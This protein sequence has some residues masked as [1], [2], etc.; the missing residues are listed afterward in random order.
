M[1]YYSDYQKIIAISKSKSGVNQA[2]SFPKDTPIHEIIE[3]AGMHC[4][5]LTILIDEE[6]ANNDKFKETL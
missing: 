4:K 1:Q 5:E 3:W 2:K 6:T